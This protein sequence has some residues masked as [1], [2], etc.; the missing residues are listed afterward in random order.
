[1]SLLGLFKWP[2]RG[3]LK[4]VTYTFR[5][6]VLA[7]GEPITPLHRRTYPFTVVVDKRMSPERIQKAV[8]LRAAEFAADMAVIM[9]KEILAA[10]EEK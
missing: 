6:S 8:A 9:E 4:A 10:I 3:R 7:G 5:L 2:H 1:M